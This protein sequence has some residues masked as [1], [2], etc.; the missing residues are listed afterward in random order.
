MSSHRTQWSHETEQRSPENTL[1]LE[2]GEITDL[3]Y[4]VV[5]AVGLN[6]VVLDE[7]ATGP[8]VDGEVL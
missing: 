3:T 6:D 5:L 8:A 7:R 2:A 1:A 4:R